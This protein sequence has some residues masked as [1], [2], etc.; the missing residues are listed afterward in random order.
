MTCWSDVVCLTLSWRSWREPANT[1][2]V[3]VY[4]KVVMQGQIQTRHAHKERPVQNQLVTKGSLTPN[5]IVETGPE[6]KKE[7][8]VLAAPL[9]P[10][11]LYK[12]LKLK[13]KLGQ[14]FGDLS[15]GEPWRPDHGDRSE[16]RGPKSNVKMVSCGWFSPLKTHGKAGTS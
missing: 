12:A 14:A 5:W 3:Y 7:K 1:H 15:R 10:F 16:V 9:R 8:T 2:L 11:E 13:C 6:K 4:Q